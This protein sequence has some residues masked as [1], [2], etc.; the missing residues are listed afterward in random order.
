M[1]T[2]PGLVNSNQDSRTGRWEAGAPTCGACGSEK[3]QEFGALGSGAQRGR[4]PRIYRVL[5]EKPTLSY[6]GLRLRPSVGW[7]LRLYVVSRTRMQWTDRRSLEQFLSVLWNPASF[8]LSV[9]R[10]T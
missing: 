3:H 9:G 10:L 2:S 6:R 5:A 8:N 7:K 4:T 1:K